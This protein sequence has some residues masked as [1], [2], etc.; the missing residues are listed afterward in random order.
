MTRA[1]GD[2]RGTELRLYAEMAEEMPVSF[3]NDRF[4]Q[5]LYDAALYNR[6]IPK[7]DRAA[8]MD[9]LRDRMESEYGVDFDNVFN[10][11]GYRATYD[12]R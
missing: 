5:A 7:R 10:W 9:A 8:I 11:E 4:T 2:W 1:F 12:R 3:Q 6:D